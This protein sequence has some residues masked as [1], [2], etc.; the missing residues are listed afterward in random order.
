MDDVIDALRSVELFSDLDQEALE[1][2]A[3]RCRRDTYQ[4]NQTIFS[5]E[6]LSADVY[7][8]KSGFVLITMFSPNGREI[9]FRQLKAGDL[10]GEIAAID[11]QPRSTSAVSRSAVE[12]IR[13]SEHDFLRVMSDF[14]DVG[15]K[16]M[17]RLAFLV[18]ALS[19][20][21]FEYSTYHVRYRILA[22]LLR[23]VEAHAVPGSDVVNIYPAPTHADIANRI[24]THREAVT[25]EFRL[26]AK[27]SILENGAAI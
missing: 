3:A 23:L 8:V 16:V 22:E 17:Q 5:Y 7:F 24:S 20:R 11:R 15:L 27:D 10:F 25:R 6:D 4:Q 9:D 12:L 13:I 26:L 1:T 2:I 14:P 21:V 18:R 19:E